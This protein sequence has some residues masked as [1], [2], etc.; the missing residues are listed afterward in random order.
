VKKQRQE[1][2]SGSSSE[3][4]EGNEGAKSSGIPSALNESGS[5]E[6]SEEESEKQTF[7][8]RLRAGKDADENA[9][10]GSDDEE[11]K[12]VVTEQE[13]RLQKKCYCHFISDYRRTTVQTGE[14]LEDTVFQVRG[15][16][17]FLSDQNAWKERGTGLLKIN[18]RK[19]DGGGARLREFER[20]R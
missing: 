4:G 20:I 6:G 8:E 11:S 3:T 17:Y 18:V 13:G 19:V 10:A 12:L 5:P 7:G 14:E 1:P 9:P 2:G 16:L 15:K